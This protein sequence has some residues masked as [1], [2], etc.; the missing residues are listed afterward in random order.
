MCHRE[1]DIDFVGGVPLKKLHGLY[2]FLYGW[3]AFVWLVFF[4]M[5]G[6]LLKFCMAGMLLYGWHAFV[7]LACFCMAGMHLYGWYPFVYIVCGWHPNDV[8]VRGRHLN[9]R[10]RHLNVR[11]SHL[12]VRGR[13]LKVRMCYYLL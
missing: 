8:H 11:G 6:I 1:L 13:H 2:P 10:G 4:C 5:A 3:H 7:W 12:N 9:V